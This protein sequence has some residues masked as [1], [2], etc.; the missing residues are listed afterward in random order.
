MPLLSRSMQTMKM[1]AVISSETSV[2]FAID[3]AYLN[4]VESELRNL[5]RYPC[6]VTKVTLKD[7]K[8]NRVLIELTG[9]D[10]VRAN[11]LFVCL[12]TANSC[13]SSISTEQGYSTLKS[14]RMRK[15]LA[16]YGPSCKPIGLCFVKH[17]T[18]QTC[19]RPQ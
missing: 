9:Y 8:Q 2:S 7:V 14:V 11:E 5:L 15:T 17:H 4:K 6:V 13:A 3:K 19:C 10:K 16:P 1:G 12:Q 18:M